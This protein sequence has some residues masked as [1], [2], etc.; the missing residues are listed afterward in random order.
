MR[1]YFLGRR[2]RTYSELEFKIYIKEAMLLYQMDSLFMNGLPDVISLHTL[3]SARF[4]LVGY[5]N[6][7]WGMPPYFP[8]TDLDRR[9]ECRVSKK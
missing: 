2:S 5:V 3:S 7:I 9:F 6:R 8:R 1:D 4:S